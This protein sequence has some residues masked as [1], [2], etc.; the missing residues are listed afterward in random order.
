MNKTFS[1]PV[2]GAG[3]SLHRSLLDALSHL[4][5]TDINF[6]E[7]APE[8]WIR[9]GGR[10]GNQLRSYTEKF[11]FVCHGLSLSLGAPA[12]LNIDLLKETSPNV[13]IL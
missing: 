8:N 2:S 4:D 7:I 3:L 13:R 12:P 1:A 10:I 9:V 5:T 11:P 6:M